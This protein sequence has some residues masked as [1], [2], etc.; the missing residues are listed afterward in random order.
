MFGISVL[1]YYLKESVQS[2]LLT[3]I[4]RVFN[5]SQSASHDFYLNF[6]PLQ[7]ANELPAFDISE[8]AAGRGGGAAKRRSSIIHNM[9][10]HSLF[11]IQRFTLER[12]LLHNTFV[13]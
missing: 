8:R 6:S 10:A 13:L 4:Q 2:F 3:Q 12:E 11:G 7:V 5:T 1:V 9:L